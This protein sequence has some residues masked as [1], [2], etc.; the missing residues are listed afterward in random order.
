MLLSFRAVN[1]R[2]IRNEQ[3]LNLAPVYEA[4]RPVGTRWPAVP[5]AAI[6]GANASGKS[7]LLDAFCYL[8]DMVLRSDR[9]AE[10]GLGVR[11]FPF[12]LDPEVGAEPSSFDIDVVINGT[13]HSYGFS[14]DDDRVVEEWLYRYPNKRRQVV[15]FRDGQNFRFGTTAR[16]DLREAVGITARNVLFAS[17]AARAGKDDV[18]PLYAWLRETLA[19]T[20]R[21]SSHPRPG[22]RLPLRIRIERLLRRKPYQQALLSL[23][24]AADFGI[25]DVGVDY[26]EFNDWPEAE[27]ASW[28]EAQ[29]TREEE[30]ESELSTS[31]R[32][33][34]IWFEMHGAKPGATLLLEDQSDGTRVFL[35]RAIDVLNTLKTGSLMII[36]EL[37]SNL[38]PNLAGQIVRLFQEAVT[39]PHG[40]QLIFTT[41]DTS[42]LGSN[43]ETLKRDQTWFVDKEY[44]N[45]ASRL[46]PL[47]D[48]KPRDNEN[49]ERRYRSGSYRAVP[50]I[51]ED[52]A[53][54]A[55]RRF[56]DGSETGERD[57]G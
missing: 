38:H 40:A 10:P 32:R 8:Q 17:V 57:N 19:E 43:T 22:L 12:A 18:F 45:G 2:S 20:S 4:D 9:E 15:F 42:L 52:V 30:N 3:H 46:F 37:E 26:L 29:A 50:F 54:S 14:V 1:H 27:K 31:P 34:R 11:R 16:P 23:L 51:D 7:N 6:Y 48:F 41:H 35:S 53:L 13:H 28:R 55:V 49:T 39:N 56:I 24:R 47:T 36:D 21:S 25:Q 33:R 5:V 44:S